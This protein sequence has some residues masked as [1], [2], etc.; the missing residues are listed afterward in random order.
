[1]SN[2]RTSPAS[3]MFLNKLKSLKEQLAKTID[4]DITPKLNDLRIS[5]GMREKLKD[6]LAD[7]KKTIREITLLED[8]LE[9]L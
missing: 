6:K 1:M 9:R 5:E 4:E 3:K 2:D 8:R 7:L